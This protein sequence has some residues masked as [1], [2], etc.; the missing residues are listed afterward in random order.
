MDVVDD[1]RL[2]E[3]ARE[4]IRELLPSARRA[5]AIKPLVVLLAFLPGLLVFRHP[6]LDHVTASVGLRALEISSGASPLEWFVAAGN[7]SPTQGR[8]LAPLVSLLTAI[9]LRIE[10]LS[11]ESRLLLVSY[12]SSVLLLLSLF[13][14]AAKLAGSRF[15]FAAVLLSCCHREFFELSSHMPPISLAMAF[16]LLAFRGLLTHQD[17]D[18][19]LISWP[20]IGAGAALGTSWLAGNSV[21]LA[22]WCVIGAQSLA[23]AVMDCSARASAVPLRRAVRRRLIRLAS[24][25]SAFLIVSAI[26]GAMGFA[27]GV[28]ALGM[29]PAALWQF[30]IRGIELEL[31]SFRMHWPTGTTVS[32]VSRAFLSLSGALLGFILLGLFQSVRGAEQK[33]P[34]AICRCDRFV[35][36]WFG[37]ASLM[38]L[39]S[40]SAHRGEFATSTPWSTIVLLPVLMLAARGMDGV[41][42]RQFELGVVL[43]VTAVTLM[44]NYAP[45]ISVRRLLPMTSELVVGGLLL[46]LAVV[47]FLAWSYRR[48]SADERHR[49]ATIFVCLASG[50]VANAVIGLCSLNPQTDDE[51][52]LLAFHRQLSTEPIPTECW[53]VCDEVPPARIRFFLQSLWQ[54]RTIRWAADWEAMFAETAVRSTAPELPSAGS[55]SQIVV[56]WGTQKWPATD[57]RQRGQT[58]TQATD[59]HYFQRRLLKAYRWSARAESK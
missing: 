54:T 50:V 39:A 27:W 56:T 29:R 41:L 5:A 58:L 16:A 22:A 48:L 33:K 38:W 24:A 1:V 44:V 18:D 15:G 23:A 51:R 57:L 35:L 53:L 32:A 11:S 40:W 2:L 4:P 19:R 21:A 49:R 55:S 12:G 9:S 31:L 8:P 26:A 47:L 20:L 43:L 52:E 13:S 46:L 6:T 45:Y 34:E 10:L 7:E 28:T 36:V 25:V 59:P 14:L 30:G 3:L 37:L 42:R 17:E